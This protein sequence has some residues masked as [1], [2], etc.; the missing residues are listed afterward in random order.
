[1]ITF[2]GN[3]KTSTASNA[4]STS[5]RCNK[6]GEISDQGEEG[7][8]SSTLMVYPNPTSDKVYIISGDQKLA[9]KDVVTY[10]LAGRICHV[11]VIHTGALLE[12]DFTTLKSGVYIIKVTLADK[13]QMFR[14]IRR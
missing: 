7:N 4:S 14:I 12:I 1:L 9:E 3:H 13:Q 5:N 8:L 2:N 10:D 11:D 6:S